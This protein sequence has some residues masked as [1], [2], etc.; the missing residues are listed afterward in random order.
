MERAFEALLELAKTAPG[1]R[2]DIG[3]RGLI[4]LFALLGGDHELTRRFRSRL[5]ELAS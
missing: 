1:Y 4:S 2:D 5:A 3:R